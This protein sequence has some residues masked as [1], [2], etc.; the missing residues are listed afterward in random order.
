MKLMKLLTIPEVSKLLRISERTTYRLIE[1]GK[2]KAIKISRKA[3]RIEE[4]DLNNFIKRHK[5]K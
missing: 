1:A 3:T 4:K 5:T 2:L